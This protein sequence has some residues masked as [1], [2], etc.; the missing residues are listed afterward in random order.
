MVATIGQDEGTRTNLAIAG[1]ID[2]T[3]GM[4]RTIRDI[5][6]PLR[7]VW[8][9]QANT[10]CCNLLPWTSTQLYKSLDLDLHK[11]NNQEDVGWLMASGT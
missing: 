2:L 11:D 6:K 4:N 3:A 8:I 1:T 7:Q 10:R 9:Q 5:E